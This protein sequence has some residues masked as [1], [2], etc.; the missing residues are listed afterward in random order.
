MVVG[1]VVSLL[2]FCNDDVDAFV[3]QENCLNVGTSIRVCPTSR[4]TFCRLFVFIV[5]ASGSTIPGSDSY[6][7]SS[8][9]LFLNSVEY[10][11]LLL[12][13]DEIVTCVEG[14][15]KSLYVKQRCA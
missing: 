8:N 10:Y 13:H 9:L 5:L 7:Y 14:E 3:V 6:L 11:L 15:M 1:C 4:D 12:S 2:R